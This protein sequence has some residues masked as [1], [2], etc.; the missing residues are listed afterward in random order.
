MHQPR[1][2]RID[3]HRLIWNSIFAV[4]GVPLNDVSMNRIGFRASEANVSALPQQFGHGQTL[5]HRFKQLHAKAITC[6]VNQT[7]TL[8]IRDWRGFHGAPLHCAFFDTTEQ[9]ISCHCI[10]WLKSDVVD[11]AAVIDAGRNSP[12]GRHAKAGG[13]D[14]HGFKQRA[15]CNLTWMAFKVV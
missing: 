15:V 14:A 5:R 4:T 13:C 1:R 10:A 12:V 8:N 2:N 11:R 9:R 3:T 7:L 6:G